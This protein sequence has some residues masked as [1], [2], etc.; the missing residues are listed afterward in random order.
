MPFGEN[1]SAEHIFPCKC[2]FF[3]F[4]CSCGEQMKVLLRSAQIFFDCSSHTTG[5]ICI[6]LCGA[7]AVLWWVGGPARWRIRRAKCE[8]KQQMKPCS[9]WRQNPAAVI[10]GKYVWFPDPGCNHTHYWFPFQSTFQL[11]ASCLVKST[12][13]PPRFDHFR[14][15]WWTSRVFWCFRRLR[16][17]LSDQRRW[18]WGER[19]LL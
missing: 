13:N 9:L 3:F 19:L 2:F 8:I 1:E 16:S 14:S 15:F 6:S 4:C 10:A 11:W 17:K 12:W 5:A 18:R 7:D